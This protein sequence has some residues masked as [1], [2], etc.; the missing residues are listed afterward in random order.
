MRTRSNGV[1]L[2]SCVQN[3]KLPPVVKVVPPAILKSILS[4]ASLL[5]RLYV[6]PL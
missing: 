2:P 6:V 3:L 4:V 1:E 5:P